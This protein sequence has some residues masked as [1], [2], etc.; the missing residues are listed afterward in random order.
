MFLII[1]LS[2]NKKNEN[3][4][5]FDIFPFDIFDL[6]DMFDI[7]DM[8]DDMFDLF[9][10]FDI[11][12]DIFDDMFDEFDDIFDDI[13]DEFDDIFDIF[14]DMFDMFEFF[15]LT[16]T[17]VLSA[18]VQALNAATAKSADKAKVFFIE[19]KFSC[20]LKDYTVVF[21]LFTQSLPAKLDLGHW[22]I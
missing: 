3:Y 18:G 8:F 6:F 19:I 20:L 13:F 22:T 17:L 7:L 10:M 4:G 5:L 21:R 1:R 2:L 11:F 9:D 15:I 14:D 16:F 12:D